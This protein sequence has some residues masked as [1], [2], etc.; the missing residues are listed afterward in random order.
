MANS[1]HPNIRS[2]TRARSNIATTQRQRLPACSL[3]LSYLDAACTLWKFNRQRPLAYVRARRSRRMRRGRRRGK[4]NGGWWETKRQGERKRQR[5]MF[6]G[7]AITASWDAYPG[8][9]CAS[10]AVRPL[11]LRAPYRD[12][13]PLGR[14]FRKLPS[15]AV[16]SRSPSKRRIEWSRIVNASLHEVRLLWL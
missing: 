10:C 11:C 13:R 4:K 15:E 16:P 9:L 1:R 5:E 7:D 14:R 3:R 2:L 6:A 8:D 12:R